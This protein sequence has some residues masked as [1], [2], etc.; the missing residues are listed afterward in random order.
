MYK[1][2]N[3]RRFR[4]F[5]QQYMCNSHNV[6][7]SNS[8]TTTE[9]IL[10]MYMSWRSDKGYSAAGAQQPLLDYF[11]MYFFKVLWYFFNYKFNVFFLKRIL[12]IILSTNSRL[13]HTYSYG[14]QWQV[15]IRYIKFTT[16]FGTFWRICVKL[17]FTHNIVQNIICSSMRIMR[18]FEWCHLNVCRI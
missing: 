14:R 2:H 7:K 10:Y 13:H 11:K 12:V 17:L 6:N 16:I 18:P 8:V 4:F 15:L 9:Y 1:T 3:V 5:I